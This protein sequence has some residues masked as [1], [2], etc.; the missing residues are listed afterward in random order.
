MTFQLLEIRLI[1]DSIFHTS[2]I[3]AEVRPFIVWLP[4]SHLVQPVRMGERAR[5]PVVNRLVS[6]HPDRMKRQAVV[7]HRNLVEIVRVFEGLPEGQNH[8]D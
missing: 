2:S 6:G 1:I 4:E 8:L 7:L 5:V 3:V